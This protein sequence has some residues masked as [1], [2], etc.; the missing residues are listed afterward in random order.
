[1][2]K[3]CSKCRKF[4]QL[5][6][7]S[8][9]RDRASGTW[10][11]CRQCKAESRPKKYN[12]VSVLYKMCR[13]C[14]VSQISDNFNKQPSQKDGLSGLC[15]IC[16]KFINRCRNYS[17]TAEDLETLQSARQCPIC[18]RS[19]DGSFSVVVDHNHATGKVRS[20][21]CSRCNSLLGMSNDDIANLERAIE[22]LKRNA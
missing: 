21:I 18:L 2:M 15:K 22:Y 14:K 20:L 6:E 16:T 9:R 1:M 13:K 3:Q 11:S 17:L 8:V 12:P 5:S 7:Y 4:K 19:F 10:P